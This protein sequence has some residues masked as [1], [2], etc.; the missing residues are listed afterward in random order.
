M[1]FWIASYLYLIIVLLG[2]VTDSRVTLSDYVSLLL[3]PVVMPCSILKKKWDE[4]HEIYL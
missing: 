3:W 1:W 4:R 2:I